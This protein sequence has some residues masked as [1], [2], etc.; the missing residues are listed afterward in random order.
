[1]R[2]ASAQLQLDRRQEILDAA[3]RCFARAGFHQTSMQEICAEAQISPGGL[4]RYFASKEE[5][6]AGIA[7]RDRADVAEH[8][9]ELDRAP[10]FFGAIAESASYYLVDRP[11]DEI[12]LC[13]EI[14]AESRRNHD[15][16]RIHAGIES[17]VKSGLIDLL[18]N[19]AQRG[20]IRADLDFATVAGVLMALVDGFAWR[21]AAD[22]TFDA[23]AGL[24][25]VLDMIRTI[26][27]SK[28]FVR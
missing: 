16:A 26:L 5:I 14:M 7:E 8:F 1:M 17:D 25:F 9:R 18:R 19:A 28:E 21:R 12:V 15:V 27:T 13:A 6:I 22:P 20:T 11:L 10:D 24:P 3:Q 23:K 4:Y 2:R